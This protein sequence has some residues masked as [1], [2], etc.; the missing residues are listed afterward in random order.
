MWRYWHDHWSEFVFASRRRLVLP[1]PELTRARPARYFDSDGDD[2][3][4]TNVPPGMEYIPAPGSPTAA[5]RAAKGKAQQNS[6]SEED[7]LDAFMASIEEQVGSLI[8]CV[9]SVKL[10]LCLSRKCREC[11]GFFL[12]C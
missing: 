10:V 11:R 4:M 2:G 8:P 5:E 3:D 9:N 7:P 12:L 1:Y 6:D